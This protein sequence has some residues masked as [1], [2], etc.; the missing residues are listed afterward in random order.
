MATTFRKDP[1]PST[2]RKV[3]AAMWVSANDPQIY[4]AMDVDATALLKTVERLRAASGIKITITHLVARAVAMLFAKY[5]EVNAKVRWWGRIMLRNSVDVF[6]QVS[7]DGGQDLSGA[8]VEN[9]D[10]KS[11]LDL[12]REIA[13]KADRIRKKDDPTYEKSRGM[14]SWMPWWLVR[15]IIRLSDF[16][17]NELQLDLPKA[18]MPRDP[19]GSAMITN[20]GMFGVDTAF[21]PLTPIARCPM[22]ILVTEVRDR[23]WVV[24]KSVEVR[25]VLR[26]CATFDHRIIDGAHAGKLGKEMVRL[27]TEPDLLE[28]SP[29]A[30]AA[31]P[32]TPS[33]P[34]AP[35]T[36]SAPG[37]PAAPPTPDSETVKTARAGT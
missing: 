1:K 2:F 34:S 25:P 11:A 5:P 21:A 27:L 3:A 16:L 4:G 28:A 26:I 18:G 31:A 10:R 24:G 29:P 14:F 9:A 6:L 13:E 23:P 15:P 7:V 30:G 37:T 19:F 36:P 22:L 20:V 17:V 12:A 33:A 8:R 35:A 32:G